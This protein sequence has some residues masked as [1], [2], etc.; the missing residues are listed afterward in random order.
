MQLGAS[1]GRNLGHDAVLELHRRQDALPHQSE[2]PEPHPPDAVRVCITANAEHGWPF[3]GSPVLG[4]HSGGMPLDGANHATDDP[5][6]GVAHGGGVLECLIR[7]AT[8][9]EAECDSKKE[10]DAIQER[11]TADGGKS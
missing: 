5:M 6:A 7:V 8:G 2:V 10:S 4:P 9:R 3:D 1:R 11:N